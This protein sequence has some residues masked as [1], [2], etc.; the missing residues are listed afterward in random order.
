MEILIAMMMLALVLVSLGNVFVASRG[1]LA[2]RYSRIS[3][4]QLGVRF[5]DPLQNAVNQSSWDQAGNNLSV[6]MKNDGIVGTVKGI[7][8]NRS[9]VIDNQ[10]ICPTLRRVKVDI[11]WN[12]TR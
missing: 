1:Y 2:H 12:E 9:Y 6:G 4:I 7:T 10:T 11:R 5:L 3:A 8:Y